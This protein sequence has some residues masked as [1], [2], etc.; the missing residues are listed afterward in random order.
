MG[1]LGIL[2]FNCR[3]H[4]QQDLAGHPAA[5]SHWLTIEWLSKYA[6]ELNDIEVVWCGFKA[7]HHLARQ[8]FTY[9]GPLDQAI[10]AAVHQLN[11]ER[12][13]LPLAN[14]RISD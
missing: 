12:R 8:T 2:Q 1:L 14:L 3:S 5:R 9:A 7:H 6:P 13:A 11:R 10:H 4:G